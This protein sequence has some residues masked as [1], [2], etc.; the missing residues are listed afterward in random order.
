MKRGLFIG[1]IDIL[2]NSFRL[3]IKKISVSEHLDVKN[4]F[5]DYVKHLEN[6]EKYFGIHSTLDSSDIN[7]YKKLSFK[8]EKRI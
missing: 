1:N 5:A 2:L 8:K 4:S 6:W 3:K 7:L